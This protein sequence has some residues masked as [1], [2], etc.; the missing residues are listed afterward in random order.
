[1]D[2]AENQSTYNE[3]SRK[4]RLVKRFENN[5]EKAQDEYNNSKLRRKDRNMFDQRIIN[6]PRGVI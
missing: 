2:I 4:T 6:S 5:H 1:M 3:F